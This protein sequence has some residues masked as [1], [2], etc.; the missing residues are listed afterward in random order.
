MMSC[1]QA[2]ERVTARC[3]K[4]V[5]RCQRMF[6]KAFLFTLDLILI[7]HVQMSKFGDSKSLF[8]PVAGDVTADACRDPCL[9]CWANRP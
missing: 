9:E 7:G 6:R 5:L 1:T 3:T 4:Y 2:S 8:L